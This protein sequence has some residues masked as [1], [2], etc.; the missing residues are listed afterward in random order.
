[1]NYD[2]I[3]IGGGPAGLTAAIYGTRRGLKTLIIAKSIG[4]QTSYAPEI[5]NY[6]GIEK[7]SGG[8]LSVKLYNQAIKFGA[9]FKS[10]EVL[11]LSK[12]KKTFIIKT[13]GNSYNTN[14]VILAF[15]KTPKDLNVPGEA[16]LKGR[17]VSYCA[18][19]DGL[20]FK[21]KDVAVI[22]GGNSA[23]ESALLLSKTSS[24][25]FL[26][27]RRDQF[28]A[29]KTLVDQL[30]NDPKIELVLNSTVIKINGG[31]SVESILVNNL[32]T[33]K[34]KEIKLSG[35]FIEVGFIVNSE[36]VK[37]LVKLD[38]KK[39]IITD[40]YKQTETAGLFAA[41]DVTNVPYK[42]I[43]IAAGEGAIAALSAYD[44]IQQNKIK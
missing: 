18:T 44:Y 28:T 2:L 13:T 22:G 9:E 25:V 34:T 41:G 36:F 23:I 7:I 8:E 37:S 17:G 35:I 3:I 15:G 43:V 11:E 31:V 19:C 42:Q 5:E 12:P 26:I 16:E 27:H 21:G 14:A 10:E 39:Q 32:A 20:F 33:N 4:G 38:N 6:P 40:N 29:E 24:K 1:M 30:K